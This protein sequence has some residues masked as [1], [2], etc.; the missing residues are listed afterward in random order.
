MLSPA[1][2]SVWSNPGNK[3]KRLQKIASALLWQTQK[4]LLRSSKVLVLPNKVLFRAHPDCVISSSLIYADWP[5]YIELMFL[6]RVLQPNDVVLDVGAAN[7][8]ISLLLAD[9]VQPTNLFAFE[10]TPTTF[11]RLQDNWELNGWPNE[12][13]F[14][15]ALGAEES[16]GFVPDVPVTTNQV[17]GSPHGNMPTKVMIKTLDQLRGRWNGRRVGLL[18]IDV[19]GYEGA[20]LAGSQQLLSIDRP[21]Y[22]MF[23]SLTGVLPDEI[24]AILERQRYQIFQL[25]PDGIPDVTRSD[26]QNLFALPSEARAEL[27]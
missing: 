15:V 3:G 16:F 25:N 2:S 27:R 10:P 19:E 9:V 5:E 1:F 6:R 20:V 14:Q 13:L 23:E 22:V 21:R 24:A 7:G 17:S 18:K 11:R 12:N 26:A 4:R 8:H